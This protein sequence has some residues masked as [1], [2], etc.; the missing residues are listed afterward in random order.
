MQIQIAH[1]IDAVSAAQWNR[2]NPDNNPFLRHEFLA[3]L[4]HHDCVGRT[5]GWLPHHI[6]IQDEQRSLI[7][8]APLYLKTNSYGEFVFDWAWAD[9]YERAGMAY[10]PK[11]VC[12]TPYTPATGPR[13]LVGNDD[14]AD[15]IRK[16][17]MQTALELTRQN[18]LSSLHW[19]F[20]DAVDT[21]HLEDAGYML[22]LGC[23]FHWSQPHPGYRD[24]DDFLDTF[25][26][27]KRKKLKR[28]RRRVAE[29][30]IELRIIHG[31]EADEGHWQTISHYYQSTFD[32]KWGTATLN[33]P[34]FR[35]VGRTMGEQVV[36]IFAYA[37]ERPV[38][39]ALCFRSPT[40]LYGRHW[41]CDADYHSLHFETCYY[42]GI[43]YCIREGLTLFE[44]GAQGEHKVSRGFLPTPTW[45]AHWIEDAR[46][47][48]AIADFLRR[49]QRAM[50]DYIHT[51]QE[52]LPYKADRVPP[53]PTHTRRIE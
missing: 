6:L 23:Q 11:A 43:D 38:A 27:H 12:A 4:E 48:E 31:N 28:E 22:R 19:L 17:L 50:I 52:H 9:A 44:P 30:G 25:T 40:A 14:N 20:P 7:G 33:L 8:A 47:R 1:S 45:S 35:E 21:G 34:F 39:G 51:L 53:A 15:A 41:G 10:Y 13:L 37:D 42:Q 46:F 2:L 29:S 18:D 36:L 49:E 24:F 16:A 32:R 26:A 3:A 5:F